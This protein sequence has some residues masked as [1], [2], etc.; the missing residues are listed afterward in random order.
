MDF[1]Y[2]QPLEYIAIALIALMIAAAEAG[3]RLGQRLTRIGASD[4]PLGTMQSALLAL[5]GLLLDFTFGMANDRFETRKELVLNEA[6]NIGTASLRMDMLREPWRSRSR[7]IMLAYLRDRVEFYSNHET[8]S[9]REALV[10][11]LGSVAA[12]QS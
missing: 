11:L 3:Y 7:E 9:D 6:N 5:L 2:W 4:A 8:A 1:L 10:T 12:H